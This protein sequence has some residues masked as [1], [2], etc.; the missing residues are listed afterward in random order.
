ASSPLSAPADFENLTHSVRRDK[1][2]EKPAPVARHAHRSSSPIDPPSCGS[3]A[4]Q[5]SPLQN[6]QDALHGGKMPMSRQSAMPRYC[7]WRISSELGFQ[8]RRDMRDDQCVVAVITQVEH[9][10]DTMDL[11]DQRR[12]IGRNAKM[13]T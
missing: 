1:L 11:S 5:P 9:V 6:P 12:L 4:S 13:R 3:C 8:M 2:P 10:T 7:L